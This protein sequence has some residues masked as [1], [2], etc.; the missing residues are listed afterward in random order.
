MKTIKLLTFTTLLF[1]FSSYSQLNKGTWLVG[2]NGSF[3]SSQQEQNFTPQNTGVETTYLYK[4]RNLNISAK[5]GYFIIDKLVVGITPTYIYTKHIGIGIVEGGGNQSN[6][7]LVG[8]FVRYYFL[9]KE[10]PYNLVSE[11]S[12]QFGSTNQ[13]GETKGTLNDFSFLVGP[14][15]FFNSSAGIEL[16]VGYSSINE[17]LFNDNNFSSKNNGFQVAV[18]FQIHLEK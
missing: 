7:F 17:K 14:E 8:P 1:T 11:I 6:E 3:N 12:Y 9:N 10:K 5:V 13:I 15:I 18:G 2:G 16:L 4:D